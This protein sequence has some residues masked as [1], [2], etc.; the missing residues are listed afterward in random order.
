MIETSDDAE[1]QEIL[2]DKTETELEYL[3]IGTFG[4]NEVLKQL[5]RKFTLWK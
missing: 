1:I 3:G 2:G 4:G 5:T